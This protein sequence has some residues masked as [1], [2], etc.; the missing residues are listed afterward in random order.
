MYSDEVIRYFNKHAYDYSANLKPYTVVVDPTLSGLEKLVAYYMY[1]GFEPI[2]G[3]SKHGTHFT[4]TM[5]RID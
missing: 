2:G 5:T 1:Y 4:Q 3:W